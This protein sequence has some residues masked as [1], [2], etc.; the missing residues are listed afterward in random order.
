MLFNHKPQSLT[1]F[2][3]FFCKIDR[4]TEFSIDAPKTQ[5]RM[6]SNTTY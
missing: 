4:L 5:L 3:R 6:D 1:P 2:G